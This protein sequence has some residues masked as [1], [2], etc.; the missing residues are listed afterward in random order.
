MRVAPE[1]CGSKTDPIV[2]YN[3]IDDESMC[4]LYYY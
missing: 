3:S 1:A 2:F 4:F